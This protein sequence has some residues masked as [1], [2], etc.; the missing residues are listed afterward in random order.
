MGWAKYH[1]DIEDA[2]VD[3]HYIG[4]Y[5]GYTQT[6]AVPPMFKCNYC[7]TAFSTR[8]DL[9]AHIRDKHNMIAV[10]LVLNGVIAHKEN[11]IKDLKSLL[12][13]RYDLTEKITINGQELFF[14]GEYEID[15]TKQVTSILEK[16]KKVLLKIGKKQY[17]LI[18]ISPASINQ[19]KINRVIQK[20]SEEIYLGRPIERKYI[21][22]STFEQYCLDGIYNYFIACKTEGKDKDRRYDDAYAILSEFT[23]L[24]PAAR[25]LLKII[26]FRNNWVER[27]KTLCIT[28]DFFRGIYEFLINCQIPMKSFED[29]NGFKIYIE[30]DLESI[31]GLI[32]AY[33]NKNYSLVI[34]KTGGCTIQTL[35]RI[36]D[37][38]Y[39]DKLCLLCARMAVK[40]G[41]WH[42]ARRLYDE[43]QIK[44][45]CFDVEK[46]EFMRMFVKE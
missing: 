5:F 15:L 20:W 4:G 11:Y 24:L 23:E 43:I 21:D 29:K 36:E 16:N 46:E 18:L 35:L 37:I 17:S 14:E 2:K 25:F 3:L 13:V 28:D 30:D 10:M 34:E 22:C 8:E 40:E 6:N 41:D 1:E 12:L 31:I 26:C 44:A 38:N 19:E 32:E 39:R 9:Y 33:Q 7:N 42:K 27:L 45:K